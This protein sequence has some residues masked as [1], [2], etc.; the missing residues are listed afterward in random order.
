MRVGDRDERKRRRGQYGERDAGENR[1]LV[2]RHDQIG[3][4]QEQRS[5]REHNFRQ[6]VVKVADVHPCRHY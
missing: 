5:G 2:T 6:E 4:Q 1:L 3:E